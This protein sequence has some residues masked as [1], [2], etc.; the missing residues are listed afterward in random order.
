ML[1]V[2]SAWHMSHLPF[3][4]SET[5]P[6][7]MPRTIVPKGEVECNNMVLMSELTMQQHLCHSVRSEF[8]VQTDLFLM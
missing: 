4:P 8:E 3:L 2:L 1:V 7:S 6:A 5:P